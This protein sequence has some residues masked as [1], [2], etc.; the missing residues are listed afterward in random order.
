M[1]HAQ[2][3]HIDVHTVLLADSLAD[4]ADQRVSFCTLGPASIAQ[5]SGLAV[6]K[7][8]CVCA[9]DIV[10]ALPAPHTSG[11]LQPSNVAS[12][13]LVD[14]QM[15]LLTPALHP[16]HILDCI[17]GQLQPRH[18]ASRPPDHRQHA[19]EQI[20]VA[21]TKPA[22]EAASLPPN[23]ASAAHPAA[24]DR[25]WMSERP[26]RPP[27]HPGNVGSPPQAADNEA[28]ATQQTETRDMAHEKAVQQ[29]PKQQHCLRWVVVQAK[30][31]LHGPGHPQ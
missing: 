11:G 28:D 31:T 27:A 10:C 2:G 13:L 30:C 25:D 5:T 23:L 24:A 26:S 6:L 17:F 22:R 12:L 1:H 16:E 9:G 18:D 8:L 7:A 4:S 3:P 19:H 20:K 21:P 29:Q 14:R 15:D